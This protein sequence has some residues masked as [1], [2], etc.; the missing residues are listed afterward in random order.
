MDSHTRQKLLHPLTLRLAQIAF[1][2]TRTRPAIYEHQQ[3]K[4]KPFFIIGSGRSGTTLL[5]SVL[6]RHP[7][8]DIPPESMGRIPNCIKKYYRYGGLD[9]EDLVNVVL[10]EFSSFDTFE[11]WNIGLCNVREAALSLPEEE[12]SLARLL[13]LIYREH[14]QTHKPNAVLWGDKSP[15]NTLR[16]KWIHRA[17]PM[18]RYIHIIR[19]GRDVVSSYLKAGLVESVAK[20]CEFWNM[21][22]EN[23]ERF[24]SRSQIELYTLYYEDFVSAPEDIIPKLCD[25]LSMPFDSIMLGSAPVDLGDNHLEHMK[26]V[27]KPI[28]TAS[29]GKWKTKLT[30]D[31][32]QEASVRLQ[33]NLK[34]YGYLS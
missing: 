19:D 22:L 21:S 25:Y 33:K 8:I 7:E 24:K 30:D 4:I 20:A 29:I 23:V 3:S 6:Q 34:Q 10:G 17:F 27:N 13:D 32:M 15:F 2:F 9:W 28:T 12:Q 5:R 18:A 14:I 16:L 1:D 31:Q 11:L 26:N